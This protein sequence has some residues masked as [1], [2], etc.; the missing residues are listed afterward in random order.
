MNFSLHPNLGKCRV[1][2]RESGELRGERGEWRVESGE[3]GVES[4]DLGVGRGQREWKDESERGEREEPV[5]KKLELSRYFHFERT[6]SR[7][8]EKYLF[9]A[10]NY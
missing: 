8:I 9:N 1:E 10:G 5:W 7:T 6:Y 4:G 2:R 3:W